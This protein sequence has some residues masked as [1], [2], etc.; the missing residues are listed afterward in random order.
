MF[1]QA[2]R[3]ALYRTVLL[4]HAAIFDHEENY[5][6]QDF[7]MADC[8]FGEGGD[9]HEKPT[10]RLHTCLDGEVIQEIRVVVECVVGRLGGITRSGVVVLAAAA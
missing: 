4:G 3:R 7:P 6:L 8:P 9:G 1:Q 2:R 5:G 10:S